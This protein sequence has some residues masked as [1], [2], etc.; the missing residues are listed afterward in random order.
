MGAPLLSGPNMV[1]YSLMSVGR[2]DTTVLTHSS[3]MR[4]QHRAARAS[5]NTSPSQRSS[6][7]RLYTIP[8]GHKQH[9]S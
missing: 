3:P 7:R 2:M 8:R 9:G 4:C 1:R 6:Q 5:P